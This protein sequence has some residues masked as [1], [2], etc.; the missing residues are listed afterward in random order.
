VCG[1]L[2]IDRLIVH[3]L[4]RT[5][6]ILRS[7]IRQTLA[8]DP[9]TEPDDIDIAVDNSVPVSK[10]IEPLKKSEIPMAE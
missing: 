1:L 7:D 4:P 8:T 3:P 10:Q 9:A 5:D 6:D 2:S